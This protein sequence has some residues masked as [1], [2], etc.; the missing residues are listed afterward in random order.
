MNF[1]LPAKVNLRNLLYFL[2]VLFLLFVPLQN[3]H[4]TASTVDT[5]S[6][7]FQAPEL[8]L[9]GAQG[10][11]YE[12][13]V[14]ALGWFMAMAGMLM[15]HAIQSLVRDYA[16][17]YLQNFGEAVETTWEI[18]R[19]MIN[20]SL[21]F[22][23]VFISFKFIIYA[24]DGQAKRNLVFLIMA[25]LLV[26]FSL[27]F[28]K[29]IVDLSN[30][31]AIQF[32]EAVD[33]GGEGEG[34]LSGG[35]VNA[36]NMTTMF[37]GINAE[38]GAA[39][40]GL[41]FMIAITMLVATYAFLSAGIML[42][43]RF[44]ALTFLMI[45]S[46]I[47]FLG[48]IFPS[49]AGLSKTWLSKFLAQAFLAPVLFL[50][51]YISLVIII[52]L[53]KVVEN[54]EIHH[55]FSE[56]F[57]PD[58]QMGIMDAY[59]FYIL[60]IGFLIAS[61]YVS[62]KMGGTAGAMTVNAINRG[63]DRV[64]RGSKRMAVVAGAGAAAGTAATLRN[65][66]GRSA[67]RKIDDHKAGRIKLSDAQLR[68]A[69]SIAGSSYDPR[70]VKSWFK[71]KN[72]VL[73]V[74]KGGAKKI[75]D[76]RRKAETEYLDSLGKQNYDTLKDLTKKEKENM[77]VDVKNLDAKLESIRQ[78]QEKIDFANSYN[79]QAKTRELN[80]IKNMNEDAVSQS[81][82]DIGIDERYLKSYRQ[83]HES[84]IT[85][86]RNNGTIE[87]R[88]NQKNELQKKL[89]NGQ[90]DIQNRT[91]AEKQIQELEASIETRKKLQE[92]VNQREQ[93]LINARQATLQ[94]QVK[95][96]QQNIKEQKASLTYIRQLDELQKRE[97]QLASEMSKS[98]RGL[99]NST[100]SSA[101]GTLGAGTAIGLGAGS[102]L[103]GGA[104]LAAVTAGYTI[105]KS[106]QEADAQDRRLLNAQKSRYGSNGTNMLAESEKI[107][108]LKILISQTDESDALQDSNNN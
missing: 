77:G 83:A 91:A 57:N 73:A 52:N 1:V 10:F 13:V 46:P 5:P 72:S 17:F 50:M 95:N 82:S 48:W 78:N 100:T 62:K 49:F 30:A 35:F 4:V 54:K 67:L 47:M 87:Q 81:A 40:W 107:K 14:G 97:A 2:V 31:A 29:G 74:Q 79:E 108:N 22:G 96:A 106:G 21:I 99:T 104:G 34:S 68:K 28:A 38:G 25:A 32:D 94:K 27:T 102:V 55:S 61:V 24:D 12:Y 89:D 71:D 16:L 23:L 41:I 93:E 6:G 103:T 80:D 98:E 36:L 7:G 43:V 90:L 58:V 11:V 37:N 64:I 3:I 8:N 63:R 59:M 85:D 105:S 75:E 51:L 70:M 88:E 66:R 45:F 33:I 53:G 60:G 15:D 18:I 19:D 20:I 9:S 69:Q 86:S 44:I 92:T 39:I 26:N 42:L 101:A 84:L 76:D 56:D 65:T